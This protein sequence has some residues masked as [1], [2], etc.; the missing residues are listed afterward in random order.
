MSKYLNNQKGITLIALVITIIVLIILAGVGI[1]SIKGVRTN[2]QQSKDAINTSDLTQIQQAVI[3]NYIK[4]KQTGNERILRGKKIEYSVAQTILENVDNTKSLKV[5]DY[6]GTTEP[7]SSIF[8]YEL[9]KWHLEEMGLHNLKDDVYIVNY[10]TGEV[11]YAENPE[12]GIRET[13]YISAK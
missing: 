8:Y 12:S 4:Y 11:F 9:Q 5:S 13:S 2:I 6:D 7:D 1:G 10:S 3:E